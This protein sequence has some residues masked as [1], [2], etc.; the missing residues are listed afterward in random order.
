LTTLFKQGI[1]GR[2]KE[3]SVA[4][5]C[6]YRR[7][8]PALSGSTFPNPIF[9]PSIRCAKAICWRHLRSC[10]SLRQN[11]KC[12]KVKYCSISS[13]GNNLRSGSVTHLSTENHPTNPVVL[14]RSGC[15]TFQLKNTSNC[16]SQL[17]G[18]PLRCVADFES[19]RTRD[20]IPHSS[21]G[22]VAGI[23]YSRSWANWKSW[24][25]GGGRWRR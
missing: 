14:L 7:A 24:Q 5:L 17:Y 6:R 2:R 16:F 10:R 20:R 4:R 23:F 3:I 1:I 18:P 9:D 21:Q 22:A 13:G 19:V 8:R 25:Y 12:R 15:E 11:T